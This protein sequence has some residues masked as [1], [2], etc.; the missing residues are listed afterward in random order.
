MVLKMKINDLASKSQWIRQTI[1]E[2]AARTRQ[3]HLASALSQV[4]IIVALYYGG[5][6]RYTPGNPNDPDRDRLIVSKG[7]ATMSVYPILADLGYFP[8]E[9]LDRYGTPEGLLRIF[10]NTSIPGIEATTGSLGQGLGIGCGFCEVAK[11][12]N[13][14]FHTYVIVSEGEMYEGSIWESAMFASHNKYDNLTV[15]L[16][17]NNKIILG[18]TE[19]ML[20]LEPIADKWQ[21][22]GWHVIPADG[23]SYESLLPALD[24][25]RKTTGKP[26]VII[27]KTTK[28]KGISYME[29]RHEWHYLVG[30]EEQTI[31]AR[32]ELKTNCI[33]Y[34]GENND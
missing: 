14:D 1:F 26:T 15:I 11:T 32:E 2:M 18:D 24:E 28:G 7:H 19:D 3:G 31:Q 34:E 10:G 8:E 17:R 16:D 5:F 6:M 29:D 22:F 25:A 33:S 23:H 20:A 13:K 12:E 4:E 27:A 9:E 30:N 21:S